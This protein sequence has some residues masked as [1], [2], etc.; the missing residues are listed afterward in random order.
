MHFA[1]RWRFGRRK[2]KHGKIV[3]VIVGSAGTI[4]AGQTLLH[5]DCGGWW[6]L[7]LTIGSG[8]SSSSSSQLIH[9]LHAQQHLS[10]WRRRRMLLQ[11]HQGPFQGQSQ[12]FLLLRFLH[13]ALVIHAAAGAFQAPLTIVVVVG[14]RGPLAVIPRG[15]FGVAVQTIGMLSC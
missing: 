9:R 8:S 7:L 2:I 13:Q 12:N 15:Q 14:S 5:C 4:T 6:W 1:S 10:P 11:V 3:V